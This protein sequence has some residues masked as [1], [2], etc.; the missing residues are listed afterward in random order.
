MSTNKNGSNKQDA[1]FLIFGFAMLISSSALTFESS[2]DVKKPA[3]P[4][5][6]IIV[7]EN[8]K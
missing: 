4:E 6:K 8:K 5:L 7:D 3:K 1:L 2:S